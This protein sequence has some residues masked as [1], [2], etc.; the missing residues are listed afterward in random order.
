MGTVFEFRLPDFKYLGPHIPHPCFPN[1][2]AGS[3]VLEKVSFAEEDHFHEN[4]NIFMVG[5][6]VLV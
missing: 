1:I 3:I 5:K 6:S 4:D 2:C